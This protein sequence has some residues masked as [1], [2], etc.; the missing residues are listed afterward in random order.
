MKTYSE[1]INESEQVDKLRHNRKFLY[2]VTNINNLDDIQKWGLLPTFGDVLTKHSNYK[3]YYDF[4]NPDKNIGF[5]G[6]IFLGDEPGLKYS[7]FAGK[8]KIDEVLLAIVEK[9]EDIYRKI[10]DETFLD[11]RGRETLEPLGYSVDGWTLPIFIEHG[12]WFSFEDLEPK[13][14][15]YGEDLITFM[16]NNFP[17]ELNRYYK[18]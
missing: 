12:D 1:F 10:D 4:D 18:K 2:H 5:D 6:I 13:H 3:N 7:N 8:V 14:I 17:K 16:K 11:Y 15:L 9:N